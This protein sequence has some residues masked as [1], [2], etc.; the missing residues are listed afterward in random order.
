MEY[1]IMTSLVELFDKYKCDK[2]SLKHR[3]DR[4]YEPVLDGYQDE[5]FNMLEI[6]VF[7]GNSTEAFVEYCP[8]IEIVGVDIFTRVDMKD[9]PIFDRPQ[10]HPCK[11]DSLEGPT[12]QFKELAKNEFD[13]II[14]DGLHTHEAQW[15]TFKNF[16]PFLVEGGSYFIEDVWVYDRMS[17][18]EK[19]HPWLIKHGAA[20]SE[21]QYQKLL[22]I[23]EP[24]EVIYHDLREGYD[25]DTFIIE[26]RK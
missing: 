20:F 7:K 14:D 18:K 19:Q 24:Y 17:E 3:Y 2:G 13:I 1:K 21:K 4:V 8:K 12:E 9:I 11:C 6:G 15:K 10:V 22:N 16:F 25:P 5:H 23:I 26:I